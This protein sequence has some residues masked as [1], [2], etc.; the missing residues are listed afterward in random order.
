[1]TPEGR[2]AEAW[3]GRLQSRRLLFVHTLVFPHEID[4]SPTLPFA[5]AWPRM[6]RS[7]TPRVCECAF[8]LAASVCC[9]CADDLRRWP[10]QVTR[11]L[12]DLKEG[13]WLQ[14]KVRNVERCAEKERKARDA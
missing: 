2:Q 1:M 14:G 9:L 7:L 10:R 12:E 4:V 11:K 8:L 13:E 3:I 5:R 6:P